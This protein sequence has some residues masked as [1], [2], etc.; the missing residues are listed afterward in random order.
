METRHSWRKLTFFAVTFLMLVYDSNVLFS[1]D[2]SVP[3]QPAEKK[4]FLFE[5]SDPCADQFGTPVPIYK[6][7][8]KVKFGGELRYRLE[9]KDDFNFNDVTFEDDA[10]NLL[11]SR[12]NLDLTLEPYVRAFAEG[13]DSE[14]FAQSSSN[15]TTSTVNRLDLRQLYGEVKSPFKQVL[16][17]V[18]VG[19]QDLSYGDSRFVGASVWSNVASLFDAVKLVYLS[20]QWFQFDAWFAQPVRVIREKA[21]FGTHQDNFY[22]LYAAV[23]PI[24]DHVFDTFLFIRHNKNNEIVGERPGERGQLKEYTIGN[25]FR[26]KKWNFDYGI[27]W[28]A[29]LGSRAHDDIQAWAWHN[30]IGYTFGFVPWSP[31]I[32]FEYNHA[33]GDSNPT[34][35]EFETFDNLFPSNHNKYGFMDLASL[36]NIDNIKVG[37]DIKP[38]QKIKFSVDY[39]WGFLDT[40]NSAWFNASQNQIRAANSGASTTIGHELDLLGTYQLS[41]HLELMIGYSHFHAGAFIKDTGRHDDAN[42]FY[43]QLTLKA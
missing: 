31:R 43:T 33:S 8:A 4:C 23:K 10:I 6:D 1:A 35:G 14:S 29:Q 30:D 40:N 19:R 39:H 38:N 37:G 42:F 24:V 18:R 32:S 25:R 28:A 26:G 3:T 27:E 34:D 11:R 13:Q 22:G 5:C 12:F 7:W 21:D 41:K 17:S 9:L 16:L 36:K 20:T 15:R 2:G